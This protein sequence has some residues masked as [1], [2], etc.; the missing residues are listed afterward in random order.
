MKGV[1]MK[2]RLG[3]LGLVLIVAG[4]AFV[5]AGGVAAR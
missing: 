2:K 3:I 4:F 1:A 5:I